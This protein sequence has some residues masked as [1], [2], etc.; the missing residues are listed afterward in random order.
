MFLGIG[1]MGGDNNMVYVI[2][3]EKVDDWL[4]FLKDEVVKKLGE[5]IVFYFMFFFKVKKD[6]VE[7][8]CV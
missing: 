8:V 3:D 4:L 6:C 2:M 5:K 7:S 1:I